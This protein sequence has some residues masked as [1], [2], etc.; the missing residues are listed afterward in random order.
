MQPWINRL[1][2][3]PYENALFTSQLNW[4]GLLDLCAA[5]YVIS[6]Y[7]HIVP[8]GHFGQTH[9]DIYMRKILQ[10]YLADLVITTPP[11]GM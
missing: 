6:G 5:V 1:T 10:E 8:V 3:T 11:A 4:V 2:S 9:N 7:K